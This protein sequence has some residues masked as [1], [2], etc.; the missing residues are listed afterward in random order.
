M[1]KGFVQSAGLKNRFQLN[2][3]QKVHRCDFKFL[4]EAN[5]KEMINYQDF[6]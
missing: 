6:M 5:F 3:V 4:I 1:S 2:R